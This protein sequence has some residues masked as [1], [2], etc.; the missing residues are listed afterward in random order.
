[1]FVVVDNDNAGVKPKDHRDKTSVTAG[2]RWAEM[3]ILTRKNYSTW[4]NYAICGE[5]AV[6]RWFWN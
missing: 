6:Q 2:R 4:K 1:M 5:N 3:S